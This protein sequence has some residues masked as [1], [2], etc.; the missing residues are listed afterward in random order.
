YKKK[1]SSH[2]Q[3]LER[4]RLSKNDHRAEAISYSPVP[5]IIFK[6]LI[7]DCI[8]ETLNTD[9]VCI[10]CCPDGLA[11][12]EPKDSFKTGSERT[13]MGHTRSLPQSPL[14]ILFTLESFALV[15]IE[16]EEHNYLDGDLLEIGWKNGTIER[17]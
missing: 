3:S 10:C 4:E 14:L 8:V 9:R 7:N 5:Q 17:D 15:E 11:Q 6:I 12:S 1:A 16:G 13:P 2:K